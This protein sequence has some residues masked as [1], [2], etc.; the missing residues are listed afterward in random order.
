MACVRTRRFG[1]FREQGTA[2]ANVV[3]FRGRV[4]GRRLAPGRYQL[5]AVATDE[6]GK[7]SKPQ[8]KSFRI[9]RGRA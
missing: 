2:G 1:S 9:L 4:G 6:S 5:V 7:A 8:T 3:V